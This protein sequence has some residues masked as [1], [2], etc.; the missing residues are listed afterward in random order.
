M[1]TSHGGSECHLQTCTHRVLL[2]PCA[3][4]RRFPGSTSQRGSQ[5]QYSCVAHPRYTAA[6]CLGRYVNSSPLAPSATTIAV[7]GNGLVV[8][9]TIRTRGD[10]H[11]TLAMCQE[12]ELVVTD[13]AFAHPARVT[14]PSV[15]KRRWG[16]KEVKSLPGVAQ[17]GSQ[18]PRLCP[19]R[20]SVTG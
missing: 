1:R 20:V 17:A 12:P 16:P 15:H 11:W 5:A 18:A 9:R 19:F 6:Q 3:R 4:K 10:M 7:T 2:Q 14:L 13:E 8:K